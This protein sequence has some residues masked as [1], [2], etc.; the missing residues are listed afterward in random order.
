M[1][2]AFKSQSELY[3]RIKPALRTKKN[4]LI[5]AGIKYI[6]M[7]DIW[8]YQIDNNWKSSQGLTLASMVNDILNTSDEAYESYTLKKINGKDSE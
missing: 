3:E 1:E 7:N 4:E 5:R 2:K 6:K 8:N